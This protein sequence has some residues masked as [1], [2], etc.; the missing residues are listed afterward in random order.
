MT[1]ETLIIRNKSSNLPRY[2]LELNCCNG[3]YNLS[4]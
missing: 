1:N 2:E 4:A 3:I